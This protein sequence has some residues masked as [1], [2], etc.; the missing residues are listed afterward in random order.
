MGRRGVK[1][2]RTSMIIT[3][4]AAPA[5]APATI[6]IAIPLND[7]A[8]SQE[9]LSWAIGIL[10]HPKDT[11][12]ALH[13][14]VGEEPKKLVPRTKE[15]TRFCQ[16]KSFVISILGEF[17]RLCRSKQ[18]NLEARVSYSTS[19]GRGLIQAAEMIS[20]EFL[21]LGG[22]ITQSRRIRRS[23]QLTK[24]CFKR[25]PK[26]CSVVSIGNSR[27]P[28]QQQ[29][30]DFPPFEDSPALERNDS[31]KNS[32]KGSPRTVLHGAEDDSSSTGATTSICESPPPP[33]LVPKH[34]R[35]SQLKRVCSFFRSPF[36]FGG[37]E[38]FDSSLSEER[39]QPSLRCFS[40]NEISYATK[41]F[42]P[43]ML[44]EEDLLNFCAD[45]SFAELSSKT[46]FQLSRAE[47]LC[48]TAISNTIK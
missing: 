18:V 31:M 3:P 44:L 20:A 15:Y 29:N 8:K 11:I 36:D 6:L 42:H 46:N 28:K 30:P 33:P 7:T 43:G 24:Y 10:A 12:V 21:L 32:E 4:A 34:S 41:G 35:N 22:L 17:A 26:S 1:G 14:L 37:R 13:I 38:R 25:A 23:G 39:R 5:P 45:I 40:Y 2:K 9:L 16:A 19:V 47:I 27:W 48:Q